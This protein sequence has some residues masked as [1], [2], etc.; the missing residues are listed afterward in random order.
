M[1][2][3]RLFCDGLK[4]RDVVTGILVRGC[5]DYSYAIVISES[6]LVLVSEDADMRWDNVKAK[7]LILIGRASKKLVAKCIRK[8]GAG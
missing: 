7:D 5:G 8:R 2:K 3:I 6:P 4:V 1:S